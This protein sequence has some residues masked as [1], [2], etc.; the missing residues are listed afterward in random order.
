MYKNDDGTV[1]IV[2]LK[3]DFGAMLNDCAQHTRAFRLTDGIEGK[4]SH[5]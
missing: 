5:A 2:A 1:I 4:P 3:G